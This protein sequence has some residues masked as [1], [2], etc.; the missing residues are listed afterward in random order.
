MALRIV[1]VGHG[2]VL[3][4]LDG[5]RLLTDPVLR[6]VVAHLRRSGRVDHDALRGVDAALVSHLHFDHLDPPSLERLGR[7]LPIVVPRAAAALLRRKRYSH[8]SELAVGE[9][10]LIGGLTVRAAPADHDGSRLPFGTKVEPVG[11]VVEGSQSVYYAGDT[12]L[13]DGITEIGP[14]DVALVPIWGWGPRLGPGHLDPERAAQ[15]VALLRPRVA[16]PVHWG[17]YYPVHQ[18]ITGRPAYLKSP[19]GEFVAAAAVAAPDVE[20]RVLQPGDETVVL[21][22]GTDAPGEPTAVSD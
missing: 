1:Y 17:T 10:L 5:V 2:T 22:A 9:T 4:D 3:V 15:A 6:S 21:P 16:I 14:V 11:Y 20:V 18:G 7:E 12:G 13:F 19:P 8:V